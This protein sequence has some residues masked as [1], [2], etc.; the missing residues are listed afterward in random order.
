[1][2]DVLNAQFAFER[3]RQRIDDPYARS[4][5]VIVVDANGQVDTA[6]RG[7]QTDQ[8][9]FQILHFTATAVASEII[10]QLEPKQTRNGPVLYVPRRV[11]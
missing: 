11:R 8:E 10:P 2:P 4:V 1:M 9:L 3:L 6:S 7:V 5:V